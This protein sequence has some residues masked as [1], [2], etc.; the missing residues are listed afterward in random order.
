MSSSYVPVGGEGEVVLA[1]SSGSELNVR[2]LNGDADGNNAMEEKRSLHRIVK[3]K[4][5]IKVFGILMGLKF[6]AYSI[7]G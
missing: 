6:E 2:E 3:F 7:Y 1:G 5:E 4:K